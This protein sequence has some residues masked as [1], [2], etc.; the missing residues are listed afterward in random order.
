MRQAGVLA[1]A[2]RYALAHHIERLAEDH[3]KARLIAAAVNA[4]YQGAAEQHTNMVFVTL[5]DSEL[6]KLLD[7]FNTQQIR[8]TRARWVTHLDISEADVERINS[9]IA[10]A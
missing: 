3:E 7:H 8:V 6:K 2:G 4:R 9:A 1:A 10:S 5:P